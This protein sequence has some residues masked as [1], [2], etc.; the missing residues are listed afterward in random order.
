MHTGTLLLLISPVIAIEIGLMIF[1]LYDL[2]RPGRKVKGDN[3]LVWAIVIIVFNLLGSL[4]YLLAGR[5]ES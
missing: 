3:K 5:E 4:I 2:S 1:A